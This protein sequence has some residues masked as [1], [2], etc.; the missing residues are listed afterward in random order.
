MKERMVL[1]INDP[2]SLELLYHEDADSFTLALDELLEEYPQAIALQCWKERLN[3]ASAQ[4]PITK[5]KF[6]V[7]I[8]RLIEVFIFIALSYGLFKLPL[9]LERLFKNFNTDLYFL[10][11]MGLFFLPF[12]ALVYA[13]EFKRHWKFILFLLVLIAVFALYINLL[14]NYV[15]KGKLNDFSDSL[16]I[17]CIHMVLLYWFVGALAYLG[18]AYRNLEERIEFIKFNGELLINS[19]LIF[20][21]GIFM[22]GISMILFQTFFQIEFYDVLGDLFYLA[23]IGG[24]I[25]GA[26]LSL[27]MQKK[28]SLLHLLAKIFTPIMLVLIWAILILALIGYQNPLEDREFLVLINVTILIVLTMGAYVILYRPQKAL[29]NVLDYLLFAMFVGTFGLGLYALIAVIFRQW[30]EGITPNRMAMIGLNLVMLVNIAGIAYHEFRFLLQKGEG[31]ASAKWL[32]WYL[33]IYLFWTAFM[34]FV[35]PWIFQLR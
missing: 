24:I 15:M 19:G 7:N 14:P 8:I 27:D 20:L 33:M 12:V 34:V 13:F 23:G 21:V 11:N 28:A 16:V 4:N 9:G 32:S 18:K 25:G 6:Q 10:R 2:L 35:F 1:A 30:T 5:R 17:A 3:F 29:R 26:S 22:I 31:F